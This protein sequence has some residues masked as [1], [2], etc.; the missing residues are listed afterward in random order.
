M[1]DFPVPRAGPALIASCHTGLSPDCSPRS[2][3]EG[4]AMQK[5]RTARLS[6]IV[7]AALIALLAACSPSPAR[8]AARTGAPHQAGSA[9]LRL[10]SPNGPYQVGTVSLPLTD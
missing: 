6:V 2:S 8:H 1:G 3:L 4:A 5:S 9:R 7:G 10:P